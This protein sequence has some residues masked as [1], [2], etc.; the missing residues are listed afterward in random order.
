VLCWSTPSEVTVRSC[1]VFVVVAS[2]WRIPAPHNHGSRRPGED[3]NHVRDGKVERRRSFRNPGKRRAF[4]FFFFE[5]AWDKGGSGT[6]GQ[7]E[8]SGDAKDS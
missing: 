6:R 2:F 8:C 1:L 4:S 5:R 7:R 3:G